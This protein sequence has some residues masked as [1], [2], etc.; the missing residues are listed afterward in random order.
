MLE[1]AVSWADRCFIFR[2]GKPQMSPLSTVSSSL[3]CSLQPIHLSLSLP[4]SFYIPPFSSDA[5]F[6]RLC[7]V[8]CNFLPLLFSLFF[9][10]GGGCSSHLFFLVCLTS[11]PL[12]QVVVLVPSRQAS[13]PDIWLQLNRAECFSLR[14]RNK[15]THTPAVKPPLR[16]HH[17]ALTLVLGSA[18][19]GGV[20]G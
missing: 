17:K 16:V 7:H 20:G 10:G 15:K 1:T 11:P 14:S 6:P 13:P 19:G 4:L 5:S 9:W 12:P 3:T 18:G 2:W 8:I